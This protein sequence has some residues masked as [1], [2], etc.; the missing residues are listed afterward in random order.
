MEIKSALVNGTGEDYEIETVKLSEIQDDE[1]RVKMVAS[2]ICHSDEVARTGELPH[3]L[4]AIL[5]HEGAGIVEEVGSY[6]KNIKAGDQV[7][8]SYKYCG[9]CNHCLTGKPASCNSF[10]SLNLDGKRSEGTYYFEKPDGTKINSYMHSAFSTYSIVKQENVTVVDDDVDLRL[11]GPLGCGF[12]TGA[13]TVFNGLKPEAGSTIAVF[14]T[15]AVGMAALMAGKIAGC[16]KVIGIDIHDDRLE[17]ARELG[18]TH[19]INSK[20]QDIEEEVNQLTGNQ[21][22]NYIVDTT[23]VVPVIKTAIS[24]LAKEGVIA[25]I[26]VQ[27]GDLELNVLTEL[28]V[29]NRSIIGVLMGNTIPQLTI[30]QLVELHRANRFPFDKLIEFYKFEDINQASQD[31]ASGKTVK[32]VLIIDEEYKP[33]A[34]QA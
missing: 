17:L 27:K 16:T 33:K 9:H 25:P 10:A 20:T 21:G 29:S 11:V 22:I 19:V 7:V 18:A 14:G 3:P 1:I 32:P 24:L 4:P 34:A 2:G 6:V 31:S 28:S 26:A 30:K 12:M 13:G 23:G 5:G 15:G 8:L